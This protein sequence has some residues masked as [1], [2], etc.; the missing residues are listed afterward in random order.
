MDIH[1]HLLSLVQ[2][3]SIELIKIYSGKSKRDTSLIFPEYKNGGKRISEQEL[4]FTLIKLQEKLNTPGLNYSVETPT[5]E[6][7]S[8]SKKGKRSASS[9]L[10][11]YYNDNKVLNIELKAKNPVQQA[12]DKDIEK[13]VRENCGGAWIHLFEKENSGT[14]KALFRKFE[15]AFNKQKLSKKPISFHILILDTKTLLS[16]I[17]RENDYS[18]NIFNIDY[19]LWKNIEQ[20]NIGL[21]NEKPKIRVHFQGDWQIVKFNV[22]NEI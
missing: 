22:D 16:R 3:T 11:F 2:K 20:E 15:N 14:V 8:F 4:R 12:I 7:Y 10:S 5:K 13:L 6:D 18:N 1:E 17:G 9:D 21:V 19:S